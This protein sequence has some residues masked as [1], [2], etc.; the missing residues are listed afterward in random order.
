MLPR[1][2][3][4]QRLPT[5]GFLSLISE[6]ALRD[7]VLAFQAGLGEAGFAAGR[8]VTI[9][10]RWANG[11]I[12]RLPALAADLAPRS[13]PI[14]VLINPKSPTIDNQRRNFQSAAASAGRALVYAEADTP[15]EFAKAFATLTEHRVSGL[16]VGADPF[17]TGERSAIVAL[18][19]RYRILGIYQWH[20]F[21]LDGGLATYG[22]DFGDAY[23]QAGGLVGR[24]LRGAKPADLPVLQPT[25]SSSCSTSR[26]R[27]IS[28][29]PCRRR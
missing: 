5:I 7:Q 21:A 3:N 14:G 27:A 25:N 4:A 6:A 15:A 2:A 19:N 29:S 9:D 12:D 13:G 26:R 16:V 17:F 1:T 10:Y 8:D 28:A 22:P 18:A 24:I 23:R 11:Q 20:Q